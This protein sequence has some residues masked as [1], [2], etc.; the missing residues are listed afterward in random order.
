ML[1]HLLLKIFRNPID[2]N[3]LFFLPSLFCLNREERDQDRDREADLF[4]L[5]RSY[6]ARGE[7]IVTPIGFTGER[8]EREMTNLVATLSEFHIWGFDFSVFSLSF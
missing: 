4:F 7:K 8:G 1:L 2:Q 3:L 5:V 6:D